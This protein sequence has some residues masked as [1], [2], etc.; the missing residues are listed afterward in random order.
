MFLQVLAYD[1]NLKRG[2]EMGFSIS[3]ASQRANAHAWI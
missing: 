2:E 1:I 3:K